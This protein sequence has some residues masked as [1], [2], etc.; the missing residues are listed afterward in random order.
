MWGRQRWRRHTRVLVVSPQS[1]QA[2]GNRPLDRLAWRRAAPGDRSDS[3][4]VSS[5]IRAVSLVEDTFRLTAGAAQD[6][7][8]VAKSCPHLPAGRGLPESRKARP[9]PGSP[10]STASRRATTTFPGC[11]SLFGDGFDPKLRPADILVPLFGG[12]VDREPESR[13]TI[14]SC[15]SSPRWMGPSCEAPSTRVGRSS[16]PGVTA[17]NGR[18]CSWGGTRG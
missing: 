6:Q 15:R 5:R 16:L 7:L 1:F 9:T 13:A 3:L 2:S 18:R 10:P 12:A 8:S 17:S 14:R 4:P 11:R